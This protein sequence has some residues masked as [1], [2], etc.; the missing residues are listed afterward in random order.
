MPSHQNLVVERVDTRFVEE[1]LTQ[2]LDSN[3]MMYW[4]KPLSPEMVSA[5]RPSLIP[6]SV[7]I[8]AS[9]LWVG[10]NLTSRIHLDGLDNL[11]LVL[12]GSKVVHL[13][14]PQDIKRL[15]PT[16]ADHV[17]VES[18]FGSYLLPGTKEV[19]DQCQRYRVVLGAGDAITI[20]AGWWHEVFTATTDVTVAINFWCELVSPLCSLRPTLVYLHSK[21]A[22]RWHFL[23][24]DVDKDEDG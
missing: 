7:N 20:P 13:Y 9:N 8:R 3:E 1:A 18:G 11:L 21:D 6:A 19:L 14:P 24:A 22:R 23:D 17:P 15:R 4:Y 16:P 10:K 5:V 2:P 12:Q